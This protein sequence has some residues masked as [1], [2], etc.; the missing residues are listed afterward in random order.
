VICWSSEPAL[1]PDTFGG[2]NNVSSIGAY[3]SAAGLIALL[4]AMVSEQPTEAMLGNEVKDHTS[5]SDGTKAQFNFETHKP[6]ATTTCEGTNPSCGSTTPPPASKSRA[7]RMPAE[8]DA[9]ATGRAPL[10][11]PDASTEMAPVAPAVSSER[12]QSTAGASEEAA[13]DP[14]VFKRL[15]DK[16]TTQ[17]RPQSAARTCSKLP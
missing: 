14:G 7:T 13:T 3:I 8:T 12:A 11:R 5:K 17:E 15:I 6:N 9:L 2:W 10:S 1:N 4:D 16:K